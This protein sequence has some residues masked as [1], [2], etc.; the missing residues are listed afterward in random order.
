MGIASCDGSRI[1]RYLLGVE[2]R[3]EHLE[4]VYRLILFEAAFTYRRFFKP[5]VKH[6]VKV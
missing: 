1:F 3:G 4:S 6:S 2:E 5:T